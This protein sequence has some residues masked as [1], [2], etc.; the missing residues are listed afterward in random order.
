MSVGQVV[1]APSTQGSEQYLIF[2]GWPT[3]TRKLGMKYCTNKASALYA[4]KAL[5]HESKT[6]EIEPV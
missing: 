4:V 3:T 1:W 5:N 6:S 2:V